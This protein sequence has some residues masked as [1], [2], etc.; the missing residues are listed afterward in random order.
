MAPPAVFL[1]TPSGRF[2]TDRRICVSFSDYHPELWSATWGIESVLVALQSF[3][4]EEC[5]EAL[6]SIHTSSKTRRALA[7]KSKVKF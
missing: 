7:A 5:P 2:E 3:M 4:Q 1:H 6:G